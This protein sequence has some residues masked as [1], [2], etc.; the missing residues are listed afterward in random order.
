MTGRYEAGFVPF[1]EGSSVTLKA[2][3]AAH[4]VA[5]CRFEPRYGVNG[6]WVIW[7]DGHGLVEPED[8]E[9]PSPIMG[10]K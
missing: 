1:A 5:L 8:V 10:P 4:K 3:G 7:L 6:W 2:T 9:S